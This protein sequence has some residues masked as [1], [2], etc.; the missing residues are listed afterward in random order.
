MASEK[1]RG[2]PLY[3]LV[4]AAGLAFTL[5]ACAYGVL[6]V[7]SMNRDASSSVAA[8]PLLSFLDRHGFKLLMGELTLLGVA[9]VAAMATEDY[10]TKR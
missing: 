9:T 3:A 8:S 5:T 6:M 1:K 2:N 10:W 4:V 7:R